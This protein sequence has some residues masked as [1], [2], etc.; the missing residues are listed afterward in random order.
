M[1]PKPTE[2]LKKDWVTAAYHTYEKVGI[3]NEKQGDRIIHTQKMVKKGK[4]KIK[5]GKQLSVP[6]LNLHWD[7]PACATED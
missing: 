1:A 2:R 7:Q 6:I 3:S 4:K 5:K